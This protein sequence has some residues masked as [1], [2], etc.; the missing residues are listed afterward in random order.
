MSELEIKVE[1]LMRCVDPAKLEQA[2]A[3]VGLAKGAPERKPAEPESKDDQLFRTIRAVLVE[4]GLPCHLK[5]YRYIISAIGRIVKDEDL[6][7]A[8]TGELYPAIAE[9][10]ETTGSRVERAIRHGIECAWDR[11]DLDVLQRLFGNT[12]SNTKGKPTNSEFLSR[13]GY[14]VIDRM[15]GVC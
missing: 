15:A 12:V 10:F 2:L 9:E 14:I 4:I 11:C 1:A 5:G 13:M 6:L 8:V 3:D 7:S